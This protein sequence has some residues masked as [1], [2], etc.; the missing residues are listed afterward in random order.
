[1]APGF[2][3]RGFVALL[4]G[5]LGVADGVTQVPLEKAHRFDLAGQ[6]GALAHQRLGGGGVVPERRVLDA[7]VQFVELTERWLPVKDAS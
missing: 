1:L 5:H 2:I 3:Q 4:V 7:G 6:A